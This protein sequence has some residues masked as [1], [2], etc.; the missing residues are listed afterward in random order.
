[1]TDDTKF[2]SLVDRVN[3]LKKGKDFDLSTEEDLSIA[4]MNLISLEEHFFFTAQKTGKDDYLDLLHQTREIRKAL[5]AR[6][7]DEHEG[8][9]WC[10]SKHLLST[11]MRLI[12]VGTKLQNSGQK[13]KARETFDM[14]YRVYNLFWAVRLK[15]VDLKG[16]K[17]TAVS[18]KAMTYNDI[19]KELVNCCDE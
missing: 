18:Q 8:E 15:L 6:M 9:T 2:R 16:V 17:K 7:I 3:A 5:L 19:V 1:M 13:D 11:T 10:I 4:V 14:A 12:E